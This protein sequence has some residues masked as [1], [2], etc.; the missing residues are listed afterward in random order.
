MRWYHGAT[1]F[2]FDA[3][4][5]AQAYAQHFNLYAYIKLNCKLLLLEEHDGDSEPAA[6]GSALPRWS[7]TYADC[8]DGKHYQLDADFIVLATGTNC[9]PYVPS[10]PGQASFQGVQV[11]SR[12]FTDASAVARGKTVLVIGSGKAA[13]DCVSELVLTYAANSIILLH[14]QVR[15]NAM[16]L[17]ADAMA[18]C[19]EP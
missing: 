17:G 10:V 3:L 19:G 15:R 11:H 1:H 2:F 16:H 13:L 9:T 8:R 5:G 4:L 12:H 14:K 6:D 7:G 18:C